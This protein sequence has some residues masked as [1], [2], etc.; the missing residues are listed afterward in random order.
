ML[1]GL[2]P[3]LQVPFAVD[4]YVLPR[5]F[6][7]LAGGAVGLLLAGDRQGSA[8][9][10]LRRPAVAVAIAALL[11][12]AFSVS[13]WASL[14]GQYLRYESATVRLGYLILFGAS[15]RLLTGAEEPDRRRVVSC[16][17]LGCGL[18]SAEAAWEWFAFRYALPGGL[19]RPDGNLGNAALLGAIDAMA[20]PLLLGRLLSRG[21]RWTPVLILVLAGLAASTSRAA[22]LAALLSG[23]VVAVLRMPRRLLPW[24]AAAGGLLLLA[25]VVLAVAPLGGLNSDPY[26][27]RP[28]LWA[29]VLPMIFARPVLGW[30]EDTMGLVFGGYSNGFLPGLTFDRAHSQLLDLAV[31]QGLVGVAASAWFWGAFA[32]G[33]LPGGR[34]RAEE[35]AAILAALLAYTAWAAVNFDWVPATAPAWL[36]AGVCW[37]S[38]RRSTSARQRVGRTARLARIGGGIAGSAA[39]VAFGVLPIVADVAYHAGEPAAAVRLDPLQARYHRALGERLVATGQIMA[40]AAE[41]RRAGEL[42]EDT[43][44][45]WVQLGDAERVLG[46]QAAARAAYA[47]ARAIDPSISTP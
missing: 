45:T 47:R 36:L 26:S 15:A 43:A 30:G 16:F 1:G 29:R 44:R 24:T 4:A 34:W 25:A 9:A 37:A 5:V 2:F 17:L 7:L 38:A 46:H 21:W 10:P 41:L 23:V 6:L 12:A 19:G 11:A 8:L 39:A 35:C 27:L 3:V 14:A 40:G 31:A 22:W 42:G 13:P 20:V 18:A 32:W 33:I 28:Q